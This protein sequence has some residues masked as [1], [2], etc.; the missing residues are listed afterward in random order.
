MKYAWIKKQRDSYPI[1]TMCR[2]LQVSK[3]GFYK[4]LSATPSPRVQRSET[5]KADVRQIGR[6][7]V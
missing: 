1:Q 7:H 6:A 4:W 5:I 2:V 3:S